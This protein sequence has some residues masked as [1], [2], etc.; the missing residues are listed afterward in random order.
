[1]P[2]QQLTI[3]PMRL[4]FYLID[5]FTDNLFGGNPAGVVP[6]TEWPEVTTLQKIAME[7]NQAETAFC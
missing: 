2:L 5:A 3:K 7:N 4:P 6:L 1:M